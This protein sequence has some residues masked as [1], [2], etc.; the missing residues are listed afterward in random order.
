MHNEKSLNNIFPYQYKTDFFLQK[1]CS[2]F[3]ND[4]IFRN[5]I[6]WSKLF[7]EWN[8]FC[9]INGAYIIFSSRGGG[10][11]GNLISKGLL[12]GFMTSICLPY[13]DIFVNIYH[14]LEYDLCGR[15]E[16][17]RLCLDFPNFLY[18]YVLT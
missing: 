11:W 14:Y 1:T 13:I 7:Y 17:E 15:D 8:I 5:K 3:E 4:N 9:K 10:G 6:F 2:A 18:Y 12:V 16:G